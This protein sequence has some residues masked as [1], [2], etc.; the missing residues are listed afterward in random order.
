MQ[1][2]SASNDV[3]QPVLKARLHDFAISFLPGL[4]VKDFDLLLEVL[5]PAL[6]DVGVV[7]KKAYKRYQDD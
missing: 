4:D 5:E 3:S 7:R 2:D 1:I 6:Q